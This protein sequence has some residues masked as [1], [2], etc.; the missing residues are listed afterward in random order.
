MYLVLSLLL[1]ASPAGADTTSVPVFPI[2]EVV[3][4]AERVEHRVRDVA[5][6]V[7]VLT[8]EEILRSGARTVTDALASL[9]GVFIQ[10]TGQLGR[11]D[12]DI[13]GVG[14]RGCRVAVLVDGR[15][16]KMS[17]YGCT[18]THTLPLNNV[19]RIELVRGPLSV[20]Y[21]SDAMGG[22]LNIVTRKAASPLDL[23][24]R[25]EYGSFNTIHSRIAAGTRQARYNVLFSAD[26][27][28][29]DGHVPNSQYNGNDLSV[30]AGWKPAGALDLDF[31]GKYFTGVKHEPK[32]STD[33]DT[34]VATGWNQYDRGG[35]DLTASLNAGVSG[36]LKLY[37][38]F[39]EHLFD[40]TDGWHSTD[41]TNGALLHV[42]RDFAFG[43]LAQAG[44]ELKG[45]AG[46]WIQSDTSKPSWTRTQW[47]AFAQDEQTLG[48]VTANAGIRYSR[49]DI[50]GPAL[51]PKAGLVVNTGLGTTLRA[52][53]NRGFRFPP[54]NYT[55]VFPPKNPDL[56]PEASWN[57]E[58][59]VN[60]MLGSAV[61]VD[62]AGFI[63]NGENLIETGP[64]PNP[65]P[66]V[67]FQNSGSFTFRG[68]ELAIDGR[69]RFLR[70][71][72]SASLLDPGVH[73]RARPGLKLSGQAGVTLGRFDLDITLQHVSRYYAEDSSKSPIPAYAT[74]DFRA[75]W[76]ALS[77]LRVFAAAENLLDEHYD[78][79]CDLPGSAAGLYR[80]PGRAFTLG[81][82][83]TN[84]R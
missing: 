19:E 57:Y 22:V 49:D 1:V 62:L 27:A 17:V 32:R 54:L 5:A 61:S 36:F 34:M 84:H 21:G 18:V 73:T 41:Y 60:Q 30:R 35:L 23:S 43:N 44:A 63:L 37:R 81:L 74:I 70:G 51:C 59:G 50:S 9:P 45:L 15:P 16:E 33:P 10:R 64:N 58:A 20:L 12:L 75:G 55:S 79:F 71:S 76:Q 26:K 39:G 83:I 69:Y 4:T 66:P 8:G 28:V 52:S 38:T 68:V 77:W 67:Q 80:M 24:G 72:L 47:D 31:T 40:P 82:D 14:D 11:T 48:P 7:S 3:V 46:T 56:K 65:P 25:V 78:T 2:D 6:S 29:S 53:I 42:H 13:R